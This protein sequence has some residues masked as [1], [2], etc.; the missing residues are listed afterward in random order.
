VKNEDMYAIADKFIEAMKNGTAPWQ[1]PWSAEELAKFQP[2]NPA[3]GTV[4]QGTNTLSLEIEQ[5]EKGYKSNNWM[6]F[7]QAKE[8]GANV[9]KGEKG[10]PIIFTKTTKLID[11]VDEKGN[12][13]KDENGKVQKEEVRLSQ[14]LVTKSYVFNLEQIENVNTAKLKHFAEPAKSFEGIARAEE[15]LEKSRANIEHRAVDSA[16]YSPSSD[17]IT[18]PPK[19]T[20]KSQGEYYSTALHEL[21]HWTG[22]KNRLDRDLSGK[23]GSDKYAKEEL[24]AEMFSYLQSKELGID[25]NVKNHESYISSWSKN[26][27]DSEKRNEMLSAIKDAN[28]IKNYIS[29]IG[30]ERE[31]ANNS[32]YDGGGIRD[33]GKNEKE[34]VNNKG[35][36]E[37]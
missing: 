33:S 31:I 37:R 8:I 9:K 17:K 12:L 25:H 14:P 19:E 20:F 7:N 15:I 18:L 22:H 34:K 36:Y 16:H 26:I 28:K 32:Y 27:P 24:R 21:G 2:R 5:L 11:K 13:V 30:K 4:Y 1:K 3:S 29:E 10:T 6:T 35:G 23:F